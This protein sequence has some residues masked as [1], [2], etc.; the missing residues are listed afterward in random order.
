MW[1][2]H[3]WRQEGTQKWHWL[4]LASNYFTQTCYQQTKSIESD[5][6]EICISLSAI[7]MLGAFMQISLIPC[8]CC[9]YYPLFC[10]CFCMLKK[11]GLTM[12]G[13]HPHLLPWFVK[14][15][16]GLFLLLGNDYMRYLKLVIFYLV[17]FIHIYT[18]VA[19]KAETQIFIRQK[20]KMLNWSSAVY[21]HSVKGYS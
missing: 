8:V 3:Q 1:S 18:E 5:K 2:A 16:L 15:P 17:R 13:V 10:F 19:T 4:L 7:F 11:C 12:C 21:L 20:K 9:L 6:S 14:C